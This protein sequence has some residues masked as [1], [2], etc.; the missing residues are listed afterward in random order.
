MSGDHE[1]HPNLSEAL[2]GD[3]ADRAELDAI[4]RRLPG[5][6]AE[7]IT[8]PPADLFSRIRAELDE[9]RRAIDDAP[10]EA[11]SNVVDLEGRRRRRVRWAVAGSAAA[12]VVLAVGVAVTVTNGD[13]PVRQ[14]IALDALTGFEDAQGSAVLE[15]DG[16]DRSVRVDLASVEV[17]AG[18][19]LELWL[20]DPD[21]SQLVALGEITGDGPHRLD[22]DVDLD[23]TPIVDVSLEPDDGNPAHSG[24]S[25]LRGELDPI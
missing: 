14:E 1:I 13:D 3:D 16:D 24:V 8:A 2:E 25:V 15:V 17:P 7:P 18:S 21:V 23:V 20:L 19:H 6:V 22:A 5:A 11:A 12:A 10:S 9:E 4:A